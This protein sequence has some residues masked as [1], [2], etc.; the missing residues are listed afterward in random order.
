MQS[1]LHTPETVRTTKPAPP[2]AETVLS[3]Q[4]LAVVAKLARAFR[5]RGESLLAARRDRQAALDAGQTLDFLDET[6]ELRAAEWK[7]APPPRDLLDR[8]VEI[9]G[10]VDRKMIVNALNSGASCFMAD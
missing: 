8:R 1:E 10:P 4:A 9:T 5:P 2:G 3:P 7:V 6:R